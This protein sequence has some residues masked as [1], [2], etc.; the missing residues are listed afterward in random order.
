MQVKRGVL[1]I[2]ALCPLVT[3]CATVTAS[4]QTPDL[5]P[6]VF[7]VYEDNDLGAL[8]QSTWAF[9]ESRRTHDDPI[10]AAKAVIAVE[11]LAYQLRTNP[12]WIGLS[13]TSKLGM[14]Q[15]R[16]DI[17]QVLGIRPDAPP[18]LV[19]DTFLRVV[20]ALRDGDQATITQAFN[21]SIFTLPAAQ[22]QQV[23]TNLPYIQSASGA[24]SQA[25]S[26]ALAKGSR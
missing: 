25:S 11:Y 15:A 4:L 13:A 21:A 20:A 26:E 6:G 10:D 1:I 18:R 22:A 17:R 12:R 24:A 2:T 7:G 14:V 8:N 9:A 19:V 5:P 23:L 3:A 16:A